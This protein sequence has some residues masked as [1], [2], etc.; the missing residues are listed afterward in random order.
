[1]SGT[2]LCLNPDGANFQA[3]AVL[4]VVRDML[5]EDFEPSWDAKL[6]RHLAEP[7]LARFDSARLAGYVIWMR[8]YR[9][10]A[11]AG[12]GAGRQINIAFYQHGVSDEIIVNAWTG[13]TEDNLPPNHRDIPDNDDMATR[14]VFKQREVVPAA[15]LIVDVLTDFWEAGNT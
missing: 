10:I 4:A 2:L 14:G 3:Q 7:R 9:A 6:G 12:V 13:E 1:M 15:Q 8:D 11:W 5:G